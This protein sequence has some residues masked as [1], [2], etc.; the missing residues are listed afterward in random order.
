LTTPSYTQI[1]ELANYYAGQD[2]VILGFPC[3][4]FELQEPG[5]TADEI[6]NGIR[7]VR[8]G[9]NFTAL[10]DQFFQKTEVN[11]DNE[12]PF[13]TYLKATCGRTFDEFYPSDQLYYEPKRVGDI[14]WNFEKFLIGRDGYPYTRYHPAVVDT[15]TLIPDIDFLLA[16]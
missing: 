6:F 2:L 3:N 12:N 7:Y 13:Y 15:E 4:E 9:G 16:Q 8:P 1:N 5:I 10:V 11:G 14:N